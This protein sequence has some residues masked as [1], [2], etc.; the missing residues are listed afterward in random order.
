LSQCVQV[1]FY[2]WSD[3][4]VFW[5]SRCPQ[6]ADGASA[7]LVAVADST[8]DATQPDDNFNGQPLAFELTT[9]FDSANNLYCPALTRLS[10]VRFDLAAVDFAIAQARLI[11]TSQTCSAPATPLQL[12]AADNS[13]TEDGVTWN[14][15]PAMQFLFPDAAVFEEAGRI[16]WTDDGSD[17][18]AQLADWLALRTGDRR[19]VGDVGHCHAHPNRLH[20]GR[21]ACVHAAV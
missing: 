1:C 5:L 7:T 21:P 3:Y 11:L 14:N 18:L 15:R 13:W 8:V 6:R 20:A 2:C 19:A 9:R 16:V 10:Y 12:F 4:S 17:S